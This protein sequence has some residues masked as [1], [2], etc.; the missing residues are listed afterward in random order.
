[1]SDT[2]P[3][4]THLPN[5]MQPQ[6]HF[7][8]Q[9]NLEI[10]LLNTDNFV[11]WKITVEHFARTQGVLEYLFN[12]P[13]QSTDPSTT[14]L[15]QNKHT[16]AQLLVLS[17]ISPEIL[18]NF[19]LDEQKGPIC[20]LYT[21]LSDILTRTHPADS[22]AQLRRRARAISWDPN[23]PV[24][25][26]IEAHQRLRT[27]MIKS[28]YPD[29]T[30]EQTTIQFI[31]E[32][33]ESHP[34][35]TVLLQVLSAHNDLHPSNPLPLDQIISMMIKHDAIHQNAKTASYHAPPGQGYPSTFNSRPR[36]SRAKHPKSKA[37]PQRQHEFHPKNNIPR[38]H[39]HT[40]P[41]CKYHGLSSHSTAACKLHKMFEE[42][43]K[44]TPAAAQHQSYGN[45]N[46]PQ[47]HDNASN[48][49]EFLC[50]SE[51]PTPDVR[52]TPPATYILDSG[53]NPTHLTEP[54]P[55]IPPHPSSTHCADGRIS[56]TTHRGS[57]SI[58]ISPSSYLP[59]HD[60]VVAPQLQDNL[61]SVPQISAT[62]DVIFQ[63][64]QAYITTPSPTPP[65]D[66]IVAAIPKQRDNMYR[67]SS[68]Q[69]SSHAHTARAFPSRRTR[70]PRKLTTSDKPPAIAPSVPNRTV[71]KP[72][73]T[74]PSKPVAYI[75]SA[76]KRKPTSKRSISTRPRPRI[77]VDLPSTIR[78]YHTWHLKL[79]HTHPSKIHYMAKNGLVPHMPKSL[80]R[81]PP[82]HFSCSGCAQ[83]KS[84]SAPFRRRQRTAAIGTHIHTDIC[85]PLP[86]DSLQGNRYFI[87]F[88]D[89][90]SRYL[91]V[92]C[93]PTK[94]AAASLIKAH[95]TNI[96]LHTPH[97]VRFVTSDNAP[98]YLSNDLRNFYAAHNILT[99]PT[100][101]H[102][103]QENS[104]AER[105][106][107]SIMETARS[108]LLTSDLPISLWEYAVLAA[109]DAINHIP[110]TAHGQIPHHLWTSKVP[111]VQTL[112]PFGTT[113]YVHDPSPHDKLQPRARLLH[114][115]GRIDYCGTR[116]VSRCERSRE[117]QFQASG[118]GVRRVA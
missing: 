64:D 42:F 41:W 31:L 105:V 77:H 18:Q 65:S 3:P 51:V 76:T 6:P 10:P 21:K 11:P 36:Y 83:G 111:N 102:S 113:G 97:R 50:P 47:L 33:I 38:P 90:G 29:I 49:S 95:I 68:Q 100:V 26:Y 15:H 35:W 55:G 86:S 2:S 4:D 91:T 58:P 79:N 72:L 46:P 27:V 74:R 5:I 75:K 107:R 63:K 14:E 23:Q 12:P 30:N 85:G 39:N 73:S 109:T 101:P 56:S 94:S 108:S 112:L 81:T 25:V 96:H 93:A 70:T 43:L 20:T 54:P 78:D 82:K 69:P 37:P 44:S 117:G 19:T 60:V 116:P 66:K 9:H 48:A 92:Q 61:L 52:I 8:I 57:A 13:P 34:F 103:P 62:H 67:L 84:A 53:A 87:T 17:S 7:P 16:Q 71:R 110:H 114:Y 88:L 89:E 99:Q 80:L 115:V 32:G 59:P 104:L 45:T 106:N 1:M 98:E 118:M 28:G 22:P 24:M 40:G